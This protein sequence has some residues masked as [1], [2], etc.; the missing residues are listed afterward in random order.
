MWC[1]NIRMLFARFPV[2]LIRNTLFRKACFALCRGLLFHCWLGKRR[3]SHCPPVWVRPGSQHKL[4]RK[5]QRQ[6]RQKKCVHCIYA[7]QRWSSPSLCFSQNTIAEW[8]SATHSGSLCISSACETPLSYRNC[9]Q[10]FI[11]YYFRFCFP[12]ALLLKVM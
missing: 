7:G 11:S 6:R 5:Y 10:Y 4:C 1:V 3:S 9:W 12:L 2:M 8:L